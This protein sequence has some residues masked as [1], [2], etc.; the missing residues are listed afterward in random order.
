MLVTA[1]RQPKAKVSIAM[2]RLLSNL[3]TVEVSRL[4]CALTLDLNTSSFRTLLRICLA[5]IDMYLHW[6]TFSIQL[7]LN[8]AVQDEAAA[9]GLADIS[10]LMLRYRV[11]EK[12]YRDPAS[13]LTENKD[14]DIGGLRSALRE[15]IIDLYC[16]VLE[17]QMRMACHYG[18]SSL[19]RYFQA[20]ITSDD[21]QSIHSA[22]TSKNESIRV[23]LSVIS[24][25]RLEA[26]FSE[27]KS[28]F[29]KVLSA[30]KEYFDILQSS[31][32]GLRADVEARS[33]FNG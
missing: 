7:L 25:A 30:N 15:K 5:S 6:L 17:F 21:W 26:G 16:Q 13:W 31:I 27:Q 12:T 18:S 11:I 32:S 14:Q 2:N 3:H 29:D 33:P 8:P 9:Q 22:I 1:R 10:D 19:K 20:L 28:K 23:D 24:H 4:D